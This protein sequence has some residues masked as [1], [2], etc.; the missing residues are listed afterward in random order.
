[1]KIKPNNYAV[2]CDKDKNAHLKEVPLQIKT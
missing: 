1:M 2:N